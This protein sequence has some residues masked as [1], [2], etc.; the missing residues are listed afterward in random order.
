ME[1]KTL[2]GT[3][4]M[5]FSISLQIGP[6]PGMIEGFRKGDVKNMTISY[7]MTG[8]IQTLFWLGYGICIK[9]LYV[10]LPSLTMLV[11]FGIYL[12]TLLYIKKKIIY[13]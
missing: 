12:N 2:L 10:T 5:I 7:F 13:L 11:L 4:A 1:I 9:N 6:I 8:I 3:I